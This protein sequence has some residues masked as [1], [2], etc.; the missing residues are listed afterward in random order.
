M[1]DNQHSFQPGPATRARRRDLPRLAGWGLAALGALTLATYAASSPVGEE[2]LITAMA[3]IRGT[4]PPERLARAQR[5]AQFAEAVR[6]LTATRD[7]L[8]ARLD[9]LEQNVGDLT[10]SIARVK[11]APPAA[12]WATAPLPDAIIAAPETVPAPGPAATVQEPPPEAAEAAPRA[13]F[14]I[15]IGRANSLDG[16]R[17]L[18]IALRNKHASALEGLR[19]IV[20]MR[21]QARSGAVELRLVAGPLPNASAAARMCASLSGVACH[22]TVFDGQKLAVR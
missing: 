7:R 22:P 2:R 11:S 10:G 16:L 15:D 5:E 19:P 13:E 21:E 18:W 14:G 12:V 1:V 4:A 20:T 8:T 9:S 3:E 17:Q 6:E